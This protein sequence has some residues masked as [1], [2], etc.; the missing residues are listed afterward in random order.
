VAKDVIYSV[1]SEEGQNI[2][3]NKRLPG[4]IHRDVSPSGLF[5]IIYFTRQET[6]HA[7]GSFAGGACLKNYVARHAPRKITRS[8]LGAIQSGSP[9][10]R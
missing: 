5:E 9:P 6:D 1:L 7:L 3:L 8:P 2:V 10:V 4:I